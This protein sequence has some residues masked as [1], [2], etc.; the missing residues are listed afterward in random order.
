VG[1]QECS[2]LLQAV[3]ANITSRLDRAVA[4]LRAAQQQQQEQEQQRPMKGNK[5]GNSREGR[6]EYG[7]IQN[8]KAVTAVSPPHTG[9]VAEVPTLLQALAELVAGVTQDARA[10]QLLMQYSSLAAGL[11]PQLGPR[12]GGCCW[13]RHPPMEHTC[14]GCLVD[15]LG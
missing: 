2:E 8:S 3:H 11:I 13:S 15:C 10:R 6:K 4:E 14:A 1:A 5:K 12:V 7:V 9:P